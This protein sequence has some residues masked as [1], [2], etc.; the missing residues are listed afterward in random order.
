MAR[1]LLLALL[2]LATAARA[3]I[4]VKDDAGRTLQLAGPA[5]RIVSLAPH[6]T[7]NLYAAGGGASLV[8][9]GDYSD[10]PP[11]ARKLPRVGG[12]GRLDLETLLAIKPDLILAW[13]GGTSPAQLAQLDSLGLPV[14]LSNPKH[15]ADVA[16][17]IERLGLLAGSS[18]AAR[19]AA[20]AFRAR[21]EKLAARYAGRPPVRT[22]Y[23]IWNRPL[24]TVNGQHLISDAITLC[25]GINVFADLPRIAPTVTEE[26]VLAA[27]PEAIVASGMDMARPEWLDDW[28]RWPTLPASARGNLF[29]IPPDFM[30][31]ATARILDGAEQLC[32]HLETARSR[33]P[34][35]DSN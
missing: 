35:R 13:S 28:K 29:H 7:E 21:R 12:A 30:H 14:Y 6:L 16:G 18:S 9:V 15:M 25:G 10:F 33:R 8:A 22:F 23:E 34:A 2:L 5:R 27:K 26:A 1:F 32:A 31:R 4:S 17:E 3:D 24:M 20:G 11:A 19:A